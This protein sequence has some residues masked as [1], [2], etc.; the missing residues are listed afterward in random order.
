MTVQKFLDLSTAHLSPAA[1]AW[2][3]ESAS[4]NFN[5]HY[6]GLGG[7]A[8]M[9]TI[10]VTMTG[11]FMH[12]PALPDEGGM[13][14]GMPEELLPIIR[15]ARANDCFYILFDADADVI[16]GLPLFDEDED[17]EDVTL[18]GDDNEA[19]EDDNPFDPE[20]PE[21]RAWIAGRMEIDGTLKS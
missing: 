1:R 14:N 5:S 13:D 15:H 19:D 21:G 16:E 20:S 18:P 2:L 9:S 11:Y 4:L 17:P 10:G 8:A 7:G 6:H 12:A 3:M